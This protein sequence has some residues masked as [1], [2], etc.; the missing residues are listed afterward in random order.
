MSDLAR[1]AMHLM[2]DSPRGRRGHNLESQIDELAH[3]VSYLQEQL[4]RLS[5]KVGDGGR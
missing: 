3:R 4:E 2:A 5:T 1:E